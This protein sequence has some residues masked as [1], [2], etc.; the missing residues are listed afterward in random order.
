MSNKATLLRD[1]HKNLTDFLDALIELLPT[2]KDLWTLRAAVELLP[3]EEA[4]KIFSQ[5]I[6]PHQEMVKRQ[7][8]KFFIECADIFS[9]ISTEK[10]T[11]FK[12]LWQSPN[13]TA[14]DKKQLWNWFRLF[15]K[16]AQEYEALK[17]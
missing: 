6:L 12:T 10:V 14:E 7:D 8:E 16:Y 9:G 17:A 13:L 15:L 1:F 11:Y 4:L 2:V 5:R 3:K